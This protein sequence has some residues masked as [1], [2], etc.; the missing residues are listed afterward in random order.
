[1]PQDLIEKL[2]KLNGRGGYAR[3]NR[4]LSKDDSATP[5][6]HMT[7]VS[8]VHAMFCIYMFPIFLQLHPPFANRL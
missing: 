2:S 6:M 5:L 7:K 1:M 4:R 8:R 3:C